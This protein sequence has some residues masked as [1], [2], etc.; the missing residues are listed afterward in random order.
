MQNRG[1]L[2]VALD[3]KAGFSSEIQKERSLPDWN[4]LRVGSYLW[5][6]ARLTV[7]SPI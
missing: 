2:R 1:F 5:I 7:N 3:I 6:V 4:F